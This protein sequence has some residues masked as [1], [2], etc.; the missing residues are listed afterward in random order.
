[1]NAKSS[2]FSQAL[3]AGGAEAVAKI[4]SS[5]PEGE[6]FEVL[7]A[8]Q[9]ESPELAAEVRELMFS[10]EDLGALPERELARIVRTA[11]RPTLALALRGAPQW[12]L[13]RVVSLV[14]RRAGAMLLDDMEAMGPQPRRDV[15]KARKTLVDEAK[16]LESEGEITLRTDKNEIWIE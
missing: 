2:L 11:E 9:Q 8:M 16:R 4:L 3:A 1:M 5:L 12:I 6:Q 15:E 7:A 13:D 14:S 10:F